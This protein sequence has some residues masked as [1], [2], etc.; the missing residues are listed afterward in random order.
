V[1]ATRR[2]IVVVAGVLD[3][4]VLVAAEPSR[5]G[6]ALGNGAIQPD[7]NITDSQGRDCCEAS[8]R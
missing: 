2:I 1:N 6:N 7:R 5:L 8:L 3:C 4:G